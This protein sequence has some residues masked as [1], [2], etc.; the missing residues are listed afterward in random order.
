[1]YA[2]TFH[3]RTSTPVLTTIH[4]LYGMVQNCYS[5]FDEMVLR[6]CW[7]VCQ[8]TLHYMFGTNFGNVFIYVH[9]YNPTINLEKKTLFF[10]FGQTEVKRKPYS[11]SGKIDEFFLVKLGYFAQLRQDNVIS[12]FF[13]WNNAFVILFER[14]IGGVKSE[15][16]FS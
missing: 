13:W 5:G 3:L 16:C 1:M 6:S 4:V 2:T 14:Q 8:E 11:P 15:K 7:M 10:F 9:D 12:S